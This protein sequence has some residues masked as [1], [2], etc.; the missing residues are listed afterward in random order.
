MRR[1]LIGFAAVAF[2]C[3]AP[4]FAN[5]SGDKDAPKT[6]KG[7]ESSAT[8]P[9]KAAAKAQPAKPED[10][11]P[12]TELQKLQDLIQA[13]QQ[14]LAKQSKALDEQQKEIKALQGRNRDEWASPTPVALGTVT[15][16][17]GSPVTRVAESSSAG[18]NVVTA[19][20]ESSSLAAKTRTTDSPASAAVV[21]S[22][23]T[24]GDQADQSPLFFKIG[25]A[26]F[27][28]LGFLDF[29]SV[30]RSTDVG[31][32]IGTSFNSIPFNATSPAGQLSEL[33]FSAQ[34]SRIGLKVDSNPGDFKVRG[35]LEADFLGNAATNVQVGSHSNTLRMRLYWVDVR[36]GKWEVLAG[37]S[38]S[39]MTPNRVGI[40]PMPSD[41]F[42]SQD[43][44]TNYQLGLIWLRTPG[45]RLVLH[46]NDNITW[47]FA[48]EDPEQQTTGLVTFPAGFNNAQV[49][50]NGNGGGSKTPNK[51][52]DVESK[53]AFDTH[54]NGGGRN[55]HVEIAG[56][57][58]AFRLN[59]PGLGNVTKSGGGGSI[60]ANLEL[61][62]NFHLI[63]NTFWSDG[64]GRY[65]FQQ[66]PDF[67]VNVSAAG[68]F[69]PSPL[70]AGS[71]IGGF[72]Y[73]VK[74]SLLY[75]YYGGVYFGRNF[76]QVTAGPPPTFTGYGYPGSG[77]GQNRTIQEGTIGLNQT[78]WSD[79]K[80]GDLKLLTQISYLS[81]NPWSTTGT[82]GNA[83]SA[84]LGMSFVDLRYDLP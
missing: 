52:P 64:G 14:E 6:T 45:V 41:I 60:N 83:A 37:Q 51:A 44:D 74:K 72:E 76:Q 58:R 46:A 22:K 75:G 27:T 20:N 23:A 8:A 69:V 18:K 62:K 1:T 84:H 80:Y 5:A 32:G 71:G 38:W 78:L 21:S 67:T 17:A 56:I 26:E 16:S 25:G 55:F 57:Y 70:H 50:D 54:P 53:L 63:A 81:R 3:A 49:D 35:Y 42:Y 34:N 10:V 29:T 61:F 39:M 7:S 19:L 9:N 66:G 11:A 40:S 65:I 33:R 47:G 31:S 30:Y 15:N 36:R 59:T 28:P 68:N 12:A 77:S 82:P 43:M 13:Q 48:L 24:Q 73:T 2:L 79:K 4:V